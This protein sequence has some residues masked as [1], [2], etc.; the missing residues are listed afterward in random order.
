[1]TKFKCDITLEDATD[2]QFTNL[3]GANT[4]KI[5]SDGNNL[6][7]SNAVGDVLLGDGA[8]DV[9]IGDGTN[10]VDI[11][12]EQSG[13]IS[14]ESGAELT[15][16]N[17]GGTLALGSAISSAATI[18]GDLTVGVDDTGHDVTFFGA[19]SGKK[20]LW[21]Q[22]AD[23]LIVDGTLDVNGDATVLS[24]AGSG[25]LTVGRNANENMVIYVDDSNTTI[26]G[27]QDSDTN[28]A[29]SF[30]L[31]RTFLGSGAN[32]F[33]I[34]KGGTA[35]LTIDTN[36]AATFAGTIGS[37][38]ITSTGQITGTELEGTSL[39]IN[40]NADIS[41][42]LTGVDTLTATTLSVTNYGL[43]AGDIPTLNQNTS[44]NAATATD[45]TNLNATD[46]RDMAPEDYGYTNDFRVF[47][48]SKEGL[49]DGTST[50]SNWQ[51]ALY[52]NSYTDASGGDA[53]LLAFDKSEKKI[54]HYQADQA[55]TN[56]GTAKQLAYTDSDISGDTTG[57]AATATL[58]STTTVTDHSTNNIN[59]PVVWHNN[60]NALY[61]TASK[62]TFNPSTGALTATTLS[63]TNYGLA[64]GDIPNNAANTTGS[65]ATLTTARAIN[66]VDFDGSGEI[67]ITAAA[68]TLTGNTLKSTVVTSSL[69]S[70]GT[71][72][73]GVWNGDEI[74]TEYTVAKVSS[75][76]AGAGIDVNNSGVG[77]V[78]VTAETA[79]AT[80]P[81]IVELATTAEASTGTDTTRA[82]TAAGL[83]AHVESRK[84][85]ELT[86]PT[87]ALAMNSQK[88][89]GVAD[90]TA[91]Q[92]AATK[93][94][95]DAKTW[96]WN[97]ITQ[98]TVPTF[99]QNTTGSAET[100]RT[101]RAI[102]GNNFDGSAAVTGTIA[103]AYIADDA[104]TE[105]KLANTLLA[106]IDANTTKNTSP[107]VYGEYIKL[108][109]SDFATN[110]DGGNTKFG[111]AFDKTAGASTYGVRVADSAAELYTF[112]TIPEGM[113]ATHVEIYGKRAKAVEVFEVQ[114]NASTVVS[115]GTGTC[116]I[117]G[118]S[119]EE[120]A[121]TNVN[122]TATN[123]LAIEVVVNSNS[124]DRLYGG[125]V[126]IAAQ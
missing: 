39:D 37:G 84:V 23:T 30:I 107:S 33:I 29:H 57:N 113:K 45:A 24:G 40:G 112:V 126:K 121:I 98:G 119:S 96:N 76:V 53:N 51:D 55:A 14:S 58:S 90:P 116:A 49:E 75:I 11:I 62:F 16:G 35:Q 89:T 82:V 72:G 19:T 111:V 8:S 42:N 97:D 110:G 52:I 105:D 104:I 81:G 115:K 123:L 66:G 32:N 4:G 103:T 13:S 15:L 2:I 117:P 63:A 64:S 106:E 6:V 27:V 25:S 109:P 83:A 93:A 87:A 124:A 21:D 44:G 95:T 54:Y 125:R 31:N 114:I 20:M 41:G 59:Y 18:L 46:D 36:S 94:Y 1:M 88:V 48:T 122:S 70:V 47:F 60:A 65:A 43:S 12:F 85:H 118:G 78:T 100:L 38:A 22:S 3:A 99:N 80:N 108:I 28:A 86:A 26:T 61:D 77:D 79:S 9:Y 102:Y 68:G 5:S 56:W 69:T 71:I 73:T 91:A 74:T 7:L 67:T 17:G 34:Q 101:A 92:D 10:N 50:G 120:F